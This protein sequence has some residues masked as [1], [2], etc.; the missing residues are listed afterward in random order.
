MSA[1][2]LPALFWSGNPYPGDDYDPDD[3]NEGAFMSHVIRRVSLLCYVWCIISHD[4]Y[5]SV[6]TFS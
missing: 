6:A 1:E 2:N 5:R 3:M 4:Y